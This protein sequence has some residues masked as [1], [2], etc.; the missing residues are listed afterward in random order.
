MKG[1]L[2]AATELAPGNPAD[3]KIDA[4][5][6]ALAAADKK[7]SDLTTMMKSATSSADAVS[8]LRS[9]VGNAVDS[10]PSLTRRPISAIGK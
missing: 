5:M 6:S 2:T 9:V 8:G 10:L 3:K 7:V 1:G 4:L